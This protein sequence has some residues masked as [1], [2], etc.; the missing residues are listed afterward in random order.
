[1]VASTVD[2]FFGS[3]FEEIDVFESWNIVFI[4]SFFFV[5]TSPITVITVWCF[6]RFLREAGFPGS[7]IVSL[8]VSLIL[9]LLEFKFASIDK[10]VELDE[11]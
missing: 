5:P 7:L 9:L 1:M 11:F 4:N 3:E 6:E 8:Y 2:P 10:F